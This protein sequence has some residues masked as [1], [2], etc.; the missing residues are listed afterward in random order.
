MTAALE[1]I[2]REEITIPRVHEVYRQA[3]MT[4]EIGSDG[5]IKLDIEGIKVFVKVEAE[6]KILRF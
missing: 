3:F 4:A 5:D 1:V 6:K 2:T